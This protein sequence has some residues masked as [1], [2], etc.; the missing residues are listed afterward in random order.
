VSERISPSTIVAGRTAAA[1]T[2]WLPSWPWIVGLL[3]TLRALASPL[4]LLHDPDTYMHIAVGRW[5]LAHHALPTA[6][7]FSFTMAGAH[8]APGEWLGEFVLAT[9]Y[10]GAGW[11]GVI[12][13]TAACFGLAIGL[14]TWFLSR[15]LEPLPA[16]IAALAGAVLVLP[17]LL[18]RPHVVALPLMVL[19]CGAV[20]AA[21][22]DNRDPPWFVLPAMVLWANLHGSFL[23]GIALAGYLGG[24]AVLA[25]EGW[26][27][28]L[29]EG[30]RWG[31][32]IVAAIAV[33]L[34]N[35]NGVTALVQPFR[36]MAM[37]ALQAGFSEWMPA[38]LTQ[39]PALEA[40]LLGMLALGFLTGTRL[41][42]TRVILVIGL[43]HIALAHVR[44]ADLLGLVGPLAVAA[45][46][47]PR[48]MNL[49]Q[50]AAASPLLRGAAILAQPPQLPGR[51]LIVAL[52]AIVSLPVLLRPIDRA[53]DAITPQAALAAAGRLG[54][55]GPVFNSEAFGG[56]LIFSG[57]PTFID[58]RIE[59]YGND[60]LAAYL[61]AERGD[62]AVLA[63]LFD[64]YHVAWAL[65]QT[66]SPAV[67][68]LDRLPG[69]RRVYG[70]DQAM[71]YRR[72][73]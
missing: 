72:G 14:L 30:R 2:A 32:F 69:W 23:F 12:V 61:K 5:M 42:W 33:S 20:L 31:G 50:P 7:P 9:T 24:E 68:A 10:N 36:L 3:A 27:A 11:G 13:L 44:H 56:Y 21:R 46:L 25:R 22:D 1:W 53:A 38:A 40:W 66:Q 17:H 62:T 51:L 16:V 64:R 45:A 15:R 41:P 67:P 52:A 57:V 19:W 35:P 71:V 26:P 28:R 43:V 55:T 18:A 37:P 47:G 63:G 4:A 59:L 54:L 70:D 39:F 58:G 6:D 60:F 73:D 48:L 8:W 29:T 34:L 65:L 49:M